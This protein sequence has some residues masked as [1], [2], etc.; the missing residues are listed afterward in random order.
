MPIKSRPARTSAPT[1]ETTRSAPKTRR[2]AGGAQAGEVED[3]IIAPALSPVVGYLLRRAHNAFQG[4]WMAR[5]Y[6]QE[7]PITPVQAGMLVVIG[8]K[9][10]LTQTE[11][12]R[13]MN[14][15]GPTLMQ[16]IDRLEENGYLLRT[17][18]IGDRRSNSLQLT[19][20]GKKVLAAIEAFLPVRDAELL[21]VLT[22]KERD[23]LANLLTKIIARAHA[24]L[25]EIQEEAEAAHA[26]GA[27]GGA[28]RRRASAK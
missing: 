7:L 5:F 17:P 19:P 3:V 27:P 25:K 15:E 9:P 8:S 10:G 23:Q 2:R 11:L 18:R 12:A 4:Y 21:S 28:A 14:V 24:R 16:S 13:L 1:A 22:P 26:A 6:N 20:L